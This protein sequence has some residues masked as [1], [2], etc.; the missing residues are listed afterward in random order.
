M[1][2]ILAPRKHY[3]GKN[4]IDNESCSCPI[5]RIPFNG[6]K[7]ELITAIEVFNI[8]TPNLYVV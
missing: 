1:K 7:E 5:L 3:L 2:W 6:D 4:L 8:C